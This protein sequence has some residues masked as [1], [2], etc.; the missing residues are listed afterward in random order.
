MRKARSL[1]LPTIINPRR[2][3]I[4]RSAGLLPP[5]PSAEPLDARFRTT[6][7]VTSIAFT[8]QSRQ[9]L[10]FGQARPSRRRMPC[11]REAQERDFLPAK[12]LTAAQGVQKMM[13]LLEALFVTA[14]TSFEVGSGHAARAVV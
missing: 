14:V 1:C 7:A 3:R 2:V 4:A 5:S 13:G 9:L 11:T 8:E 6:A 12:S 10:F